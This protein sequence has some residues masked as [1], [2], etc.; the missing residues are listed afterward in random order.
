MNREEQTIKRKSWSIGEMIRYL[1]EKQQISLECLSRGL[2]SISTLSRIENNERTLSILLAQRLLGRLGWKICEF[3]SYCSDKEFDWYERRVEIQELKKQKDLIQMKSMLE[4]YEIEIRSKQQD[5][6]Q[7]QFLMEG[8]AFFMIEEGKYEEAVL[9]IK[10][11]ISLTVNGWE[12]AGI[13][14]LGFEEIELFCMLADVY[15]KLKERESAYSIWE[16]LLS[17]LENRKVNKKQIAEPYTY[18]I[19]RIVPYMLNCKMARKGA[20]LCRKGIQTASDTLNLNFCCELLYWKAKCIKELYQYGKVEK[21]ELIQSYQFAY[22]VCSSFGKMEL[23]QEMQEY[24][25]EEAEDGHL[26]N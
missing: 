25:K 9:L 13:S 6:L 10:E 18:V 15:E 12:E 14:L 19:S 17:Y 26:S 16:R 21:L 7:E 2:C 24:L 3:E 1:R 20:E 8:K 5:H 23:A 22:Y 11:A 4:Q